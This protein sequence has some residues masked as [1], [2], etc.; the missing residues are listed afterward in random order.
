MTDM[1]HRTLQDQGE[2][3][4][5]GKSFLKTP[6]TCILWEGK[7]YHVLPYIWTLVPTV[8]LAPDKGRPL[9]VPAA[10]LADAVEVPAQQ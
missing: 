2:K 4:L 9:M 7:R 5:R 10:H 6:G 1:T 8:K 3:V